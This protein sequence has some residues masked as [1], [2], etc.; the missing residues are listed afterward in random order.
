MTW[1]LVYAGEEVNR[2]FA[3]VCNTPAWLTQLFARLQKAEVDV[4]L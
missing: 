4:G 2:P 3:T 1:D